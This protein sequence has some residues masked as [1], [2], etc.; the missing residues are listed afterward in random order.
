MRNRRDRFTLLCALTLCMH[1]SPCMVPAL[2]WPSTVRYTAHIL[3]R[4]SGSRAHRLTTP[5]SDLNSFKSPN[6]IISDCY[7]HMLG[8]QFSSPSRLPCY[9]LLFSFFLSFSLIVFVKTLTFW[10]LNSRGKFCFLIVCGG[11]LEYLHRRRA[12]C[13]RQR[14]ENLVS[15]E[16]MSGPPC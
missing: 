9:F 10:I 11:G 5:S 3:A 8:K 16:E 4:G 14:K 13:R 6:A 15:G 7:W 12:K 1:L 2:L